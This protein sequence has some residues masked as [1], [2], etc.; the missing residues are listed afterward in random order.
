MIARHT[1]PEFRHKRGTWALV[2]ESEAALRMVADNFERVLQLVAVRTERGGNCVV[3]GKDIA[4]D[5]RTHMHAHTH[6][7]TCV[8]AQLTFISLESYSGM[9]SHKHVRCHNTCIL[10]DKNVLF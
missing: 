9:Y 5:K 3:R 1:F 2:R 8:F 4:S 6:T 10:F 7:C